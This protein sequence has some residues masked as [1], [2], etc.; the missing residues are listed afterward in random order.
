MVWLH[1]QL[2]DG[3][4]QGIGLRL[5]NRSAALS[6]LGG[7]LGQ[8]RKERVQFLSH[9]GRR[10]E[11]GVSRNFFADPVPDG[12]IGVEIRAV[13]RQG[14]QPQV[15][16]GVARYARISAPRWTGLL[17]QI[18]MS[19]SMCFARNCCRKATEVSAVQFPITAMD[20]TSPVSRQ[21]PE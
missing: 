6:G 13:G 10:A 7:A 16:P 19:V 21:M 5:E 1:R 14:D 8:P 12:L 15:R 20:S 11:A 3:R 18:T 17:S 4:Q 2:V 9:L